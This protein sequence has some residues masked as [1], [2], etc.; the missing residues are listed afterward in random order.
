M[1]PIELTKNIEPMEPSAASLFA[2]DGS[3]V[4]LSQPQTQADED[5]VIAERI[6]GFSF[7]HGYF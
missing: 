1:P 6:A 4:R 3:G 5:Q 7:C 2:S